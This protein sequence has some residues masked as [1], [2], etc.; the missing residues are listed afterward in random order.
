MIDNINE[1]RTFITAAQ[2]GSFTKAAAKLDVST[3]ALSHSI[4]KLEEQL[5]IK[6]FNRTTRS[7]ATTEAGEQLFQN[8]LPLFE[9]IEDNLNALSTFRNTLKGKLRINGNDHVFLFI[10]W[11]KLMAFAE[12]YPEMELELTSDTK[13]V[14]IVAGRFDAGIRLG[15]DVAQDMIAVRLSDKMQMAVVGTPEYF[16]KKA[17]PKKVEDLGEHECLLVRLPTSDSIMTWEFQPA[18]KSAPVVKFHPKGQLCFNNSHL[19]SRAVLAGK[20]LA[21]LPIDTMQPYLD[22]GELVEVLSNVAISYDGYHL[23]YPNR[24]QNSPLFK[25]LVAALKI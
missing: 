12:Q 4:R 6:L 24:R 10:L 3:S 15:S 18:K 13:F 19:I 2:E 25:A 11:D 22:S 21:W 14:D 17:T 16:A 1:L 20:G 23:Y 9:S 7:I 5:N 8:L